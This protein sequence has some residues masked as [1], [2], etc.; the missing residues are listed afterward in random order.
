MFYLVYKAT[1]LQLALFGSVTYSLGVYGIISNNRNL[2]VLLM[3]AELALLGLVL[4]F[5]FLSVCMGRPLGQV[6]A[7]LIP[8]A[9]AAESC[10]LCGR[11]LAARVVLLPINRLGGLCLSQ[12]P[13]LVVNAFIT[14]TTHAAIRHSYIFQ[15]SNLVD[16]CVCSFSDFILYFSCTSLQ[17]LI[18]GTGSANLCLC[19]SQSF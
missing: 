19:F 15:S 10:W 11:A 8:I 9:A 4:N 5:V 16:R 14:L 3:C 18:Y 6:Y 1:L 2:L 7:L 13:Y 17:L 12:Y